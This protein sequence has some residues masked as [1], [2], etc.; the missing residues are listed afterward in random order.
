MMKN[1]RM[2]FLPK[3]NYKCTCKHR[4]KDDTCPLMTV[5]KILFTLTYLARCKHDTWTWKVKVVCLWRVNPASTRRLISKFAKGLVQIIR[6]G[7]NCKTPINILLNSLI[8][9]L[10]YGHFDQM[11]DLMA[12]LSD[13]K[14]NVDPSIF[15]SYHMKVLSGCNRCD[16][17][18]CW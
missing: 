11:D 15:N 7:F 10:E 2:C 17:D 5:R 9:L 12:T 1:K 6:S 18:T 4:K 8:V 16:M 14:I 3:S 13:T